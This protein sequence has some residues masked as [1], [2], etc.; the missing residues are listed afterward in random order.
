MWYRALVFMH[1][2]A[3]LAFLAAHGT[4]IGVALRIRQ[5]TNPTRIRGYLELSRD[6]VVFIHLTLFLVVITGVAL[7]FVGGLWN[8]GWIWAS[9]VVLVLL[10]ISMY[11]LGTTYYDRIRRDLGALQFYGKTP[12]SEVPAALPANAASHVHS[13][14][15]FLLSGIGASGLAVLVWLMMFKPF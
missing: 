9:I 1:V 6:A 13:F 2:L 5:E 15:P 8:R 11:Q 14:R 7:A 12:P 3:V 10:W 4:P